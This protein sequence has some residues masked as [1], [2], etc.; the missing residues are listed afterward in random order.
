MET[1]IRNNQV[2]WKVIDGGRDLFVK[3]L[4]T[5]RNWN[6]V[7]AHYVRIESGGDIAVH[8]HDRQSETHFVVFGSGTAMVAGE[9]AE[10]NAGDIILAPAG[11]PHGL[12]NRSSYELILLCIFN[13]PLA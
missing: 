9:S 1:V 8:T 5:S 3:D 7:S 13:P 12:S 6:V 10:V 2:S 11:T 4:V